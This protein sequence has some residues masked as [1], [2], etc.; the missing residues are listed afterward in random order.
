MLSVNVLDEP[1]DLVTAHQSFGDQWQVI[2]K[3]HVSYG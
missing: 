2:H 1:I 3:Q